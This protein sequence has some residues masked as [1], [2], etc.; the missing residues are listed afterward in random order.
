MIMREAVKEFTKSFPNEV[1]KDLMFTCEKAEGHFGFGSAS[2]FSFSDET[3]GT[4]KDSEWYIEKVRNHYKL[5]HL[6]NGYQLLLIADMGSEGQNAADCLADDRFKD[7]LIE[8]CKKRPKET[9]YGGVF[10]ANLDHYDSFCAFC[11]T[12]GQLIFAYYGLADENTERVVYTTN[13]SD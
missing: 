9:F 1:Q 8:V 2:V 10:G 6:V 3:V 4:L 12:E 5:L 13:Y 11:Y 7:T